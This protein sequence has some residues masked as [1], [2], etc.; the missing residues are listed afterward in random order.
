MAG[1]T[2]DN[3]S[4]EKDFAIQTEIFRGMMWPLNMIIQTG[5]KSNYR[6]II[7]LKEVQKLLSVLQLAKLL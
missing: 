3:R 7:D 6:M 4:E 1:L 5:R 2:H